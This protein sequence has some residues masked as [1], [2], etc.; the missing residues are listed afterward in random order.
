MS[1]LHRDIVANRP[2]SLDFVAA[3]GR[4]ICQSVL[5][6]CCLSISLTCRLL[7]PC[8]T[9]WYVDESAV[10]T[11]PPGPSPATESCEAKSLHTDPSPPQ[12][13]VSPR[14]SFSGVLAEAGSTNGKN[15]SRG[16][17]GD[18]VVPSEVGHVSDGVVLPTLHCETEFPLHCYRRDGKCCS[19]TTWT[20]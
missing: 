12:P 9:L 4:C 18:I 20:R 7:R 5:C 10:A 16:V 17:S 3:S 6:C 11:T 14:S 19:Q 1:P 15:V 2:D 13:G 8:P